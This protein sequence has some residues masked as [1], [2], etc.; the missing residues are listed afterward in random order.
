MGLY[1][2]FAAGDADAFEAVFRQFQAEVYGWILR[3]VRDPARADDLTVETFWR[4][5]RSRHR[6]DPRRPFGAWA[7]RIATRVAID[8]LKEHSRELQLSENAAATTGADPAWQREVHEGVAEAFGSLPAKLRAAATLAL[9][10]EQP[11]EEIAAALGTST[12]AVKSRVFRAVRLLRKK[13]ERLGI[14]P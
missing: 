10:E 7:R 9:I 3:I 13:L 11:Y 1:E 8:H 6:F 5:Y 12:V 14:R 4:I 2:Q